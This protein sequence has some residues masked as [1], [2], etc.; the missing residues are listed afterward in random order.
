MQDTHIVLGLLQHGKFEQVEVLHPLIFHQVG[1]PFLLYTGHVEYV[2]PG[3]GV[4]GKVRVFYIFYMMNVAILLV[5][6]RHLQLFGSNEMKRRVEMT[7]GHQQ[8]M[9]GTSV[10]QI[11]YHIN[12]Q[13]VERALRLINRVKIQHGLR[14]MLVGPVARI[15]NGHRRHLG[16]ITGRPFEIMPHDN[17]IG[18]IAYHH[19]GVLQGFALGGTG[20]FRV[21]KPDDARSQTIRC[22]FKTQ[23]C[24][25]RRFKKQ[26]SHDFTLQQLPVG[27]FLKLSGHSK[28]I[29]D[30]LFGMV[31]NSHQTPVFHF[32][33][34]FA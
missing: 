1:K 20:H 14:R 24:P 18:I 25:R 19:D 5:H 10:F 31:C 12:L 17:Q 21:G 27:M 30:L 34:L 15:D 32:G 26:S 2:R 6:I 13:V 4:G 22:R 33:F 7:H 11:T 8:R 28:Q 9:Y 16:S 23:P 29:H 3:N